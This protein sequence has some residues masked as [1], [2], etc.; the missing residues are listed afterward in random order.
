ML[1]M[2]ITNKSAFYCQFTLKTSV[3]RLKLKLLLSVHQFRYSSMN[4]HIQESTWL[5]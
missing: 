2:S 4:L 3:T 5:F 1:T